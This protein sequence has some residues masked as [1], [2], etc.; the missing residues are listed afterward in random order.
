[1]RLN[2]GLRAVTLVTVFVTCL[3]L[4]GCGGGGGGGGEKPSKPDHPNPGD[5][6][7]TSKV[8]G[9]SLERCNTGTMLISV[10]SK[11]ET[12][13]IEDIELFLATFRKDGSVLY[14]EEQDGVKLLETEDE[15]VRI[16]E[17]DYEKVVENLYERLT[18]SLPANMDIEGYDETSH[19]LLI[20]ARHGQEEIKVAEIE[21]FLFWHSNMRVPLNDDEGRYVMK[22]EELESDDI[23]YDD[24]YYD[25]QY[26]TDES[27]T[28]KDE[29]ESQASTDETSATTS[30]CNTEE[31]EEDVSPE[32]HFVEMRPAMW[33]DDSSEEMLAD[34]YPA[35]TKYVFSSDT[36]WR[37][38]YKM[39]F[40]IG[41]IRSIGEAEWV[42]GNYEL[43]IPFPIHKDDSDQWTF[44]VIY[45]TR[46]TDEEAEENSSKTDEEE[47]QS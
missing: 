12:A 21:E 17:I 32:I 39:E 37:A 4:S 30:E 47:T 3:L 6:P 2:V 13:P 23:D 43:E 5:I 10:H 29:N 15:G 16:Y 22:S 44:T 34:Y 28:E 33:D 18:G 25:E 24:D 7:S 41:D 14:Y 19:H 11:T 27:E 40:E 45:K 8:F 1:M 20:T 38:A 9:A 46:S 42:D 31:N 36:N 26:E 35:G